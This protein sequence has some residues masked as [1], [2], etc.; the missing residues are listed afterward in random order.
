MGM[1]LLVLQTQHQI[2]AQ[3]E[4]VQATALQSVWAIAPHHIIEP[5]VILAGEAGATVYVLL[6]GDDTP[7]LLPSLVGLSCFIVFC[8]KH[9]PWIHFH[10]IS[11]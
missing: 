6:E 3:S 9:V 4:K 8:H 2:E 1:V 10:K 11:M 5:R 7:V